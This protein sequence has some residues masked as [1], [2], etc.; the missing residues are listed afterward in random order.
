MAAGT[1]KIAGL[2]IRWIEEKIMC[3]IIY[4]PKGVPVPIELLN[5]ASQ[6]NPHGYGL[7][8][9]TGPQKISIHRHPHSCFDELRRVYHNVAKHECVIHLRLR[10][11]GNITKMNTHP[12]QVTKDIFMA[13]N[14]TLDIHC[15]LPG[16]SDSWHMA[17]DFLTPLLQHKPKLLLSKAFQDH[18][19]AK[20]GS[21]NRLVFMDAHHRKTIIINRELG[22]EYQ[23]LWLSNTRWLDAASF[24]LNPPV[25]AA[26]QTH[27]KPV[28]HQ[29][30]YPGNAKIYPYLDAR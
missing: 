6:Y 22:V 1:E 24:G 7:M 27:Y 25:A 9:L 19:T 20:I 3:L 26:V 15:R 5:S 11:R 2:R 4:K 30:R 16:R 8:A 18:I 17:N 12:F 29:I 21:N 14:G 28:T 13:H 10:T 23:D